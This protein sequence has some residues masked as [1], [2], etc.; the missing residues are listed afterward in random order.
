MKESSVA[1]HKTSESAVVVDPTPTMPPS[2]PAVP[3]TM[4][5]AAEGHEMNHTEAGPAPDAT[6]DISLASVGAE[7]SQGQD[8]SSNYSMADSCS[9]DDW[10]PE[11][12]PPTEIACPRTTDKSSSLSTGTGANSEASM[13]FIL[14]IVRKRASSAA[15]PPAIDTNTNMDSKSPAIDTSI[16]KDATGTHNSAVVS[17]AGAHHVSSNGVSQAS[18]SAKEALVNRYQSYPTQSSKKEGKPNNQAGIVAVGI[19]AAHENLNIP[20]PSAP[21]AYA[22]SP[23]TLTAPLSV[24]EAT[25]ESA[26]EAAVTEPLEAVET[27]NAQC[28]TTIEGASS[29]GSSA[30]VLLEATLVDGYGS[31]NSIRP[32]VQAVPLEQWC[33][34]DCRA[35]A[36]NCSSKRATILSSLLLLT[37]VL[38]LGIGLGLG[39]SGNGNSKSTL[40]TI[41]YR[42]I[43]KCGVGSYSPALHFFDENGERTGFDVALVSTLH[44]YMLTASKDTNMQY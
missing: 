43:L 24:D 12:R 4:V 33:T 20:E 42:G 7:M 29:F 28:S 31:Y 36:K 27:G 37:I 8:A 40:Q 26:L 17:R 11:S 9:T 34:L 2:F 3:K 18:S 6:G 16:V 15:K 5:S 13:D 38:A 10:K 39:L 44:F 1:V 14:D 22:Q 21:G 41:Q 32:L 23:S 19:T 25:E 30:D 35:I